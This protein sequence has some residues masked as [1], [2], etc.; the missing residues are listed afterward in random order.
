MFVCTSQ[1]KTVNQ[2]TYHI[3]DKRKA[4][5]IIS[6]FMYICMHVCMYALLFFF[7]LFFTFDFSGENCHSNAFGQ[8]FFC[9]GFKAFAGCLSNYRMTM[10][11]IVVYHILIIVTTEKKRW[12][13]VCVFVSLLNI[14]VDLNYF[15]MLGLIE[16][17]FS[18]ELRLICLLFIHFVFIFLYFFFDFY[19]Q[20]MLSC[21]KIF[22]CRV[23]IY[24]I[25]GFDLEMQWMNEWIDE[26]NL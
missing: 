18:V 23:R 6:R 2:S 21:W 14:F 11:K 25:S 26:E 12:Q 1:A 20:I 7:C 17:S 15:L 5:A 8:L 4:S 16:E 3:W 9:S 19:A 13:F 10:C 24:L 22:E